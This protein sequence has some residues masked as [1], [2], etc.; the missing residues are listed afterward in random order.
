MQLSYDK[1]MVEAMLGQKG[2]TFQPELILSLLAEADV[3][4]GMPVEA[5]TDAEKQCKPLADADKWAG[6]ALLTLGMEQDAAGAVKYAAER[7]VP[8]MQMGRVY[9]TAGAAVAAGV[10]VVPAVSGK[11]AAGTSDGPLK[12]FSVGSAAADGDLLLIELVGKQ[13]TH[14]T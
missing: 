10:E 5:G 2:G 1:H 13:G 9:V 12:A 8:V 11:F 6:V 3:G 7:M 14:T 4:I